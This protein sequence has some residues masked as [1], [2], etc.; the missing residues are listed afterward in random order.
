M[1]RSSVVKSLSRLTLR[2][3]SATGPLSGEDWIRTFL[4]LEELEGREVPAPLISSP[5]TSGSFA[6]LPENGAAASSI[7]FSGCTTFSLSDSGCATPYV[8]ELTVGNGQLTVDATT[9]QTIYGLT[10]IGRAHV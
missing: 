1:K 7:A 8:A 10:E 4:K 2:L 3:P 9:A 6:V 5:F